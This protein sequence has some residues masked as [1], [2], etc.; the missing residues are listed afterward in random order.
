LEVVFVISFEI[1]ITVFFKF[2][3]VSFLKLLYL[4]V[5]EPCFK[6]I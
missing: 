4:L 5:C 3:F 1:F 6:K 2:I